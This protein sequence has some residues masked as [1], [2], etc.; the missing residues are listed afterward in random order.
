M[1]Q[2]RKHY[3]FLLEKVLQLLATPARISGYDQNEN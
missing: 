2:G 3:E 1:Q